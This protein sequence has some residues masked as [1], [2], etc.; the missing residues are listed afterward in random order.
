MTVAQSIQPGLPVSPTSIAD[1]EPT[2]PLARAVP[3][4]QEA[5]RAAQ[6]LIMRNRSNQGPH[7]LH[8]PEPLSEQLSS[9]TTWP[10]SP[11]TQSAPPEIGE[12]QGPSPSGPALLESNGDGLLGGQGLLMDNP[13]NAA[14]FQDHLDPD[15]VFIPDAYGPSS[16]FL[17]SSTQ[18][19]NVP[20]TDPI[21][22][23]ASSQHGT[24]PSSMTPSLVDG[25]KYLRLFRNLDRP[26]LRSLARNYNVD[27]L[28]DL[29]SQWL[30]STIKI[31]D[32]AEEFSGITLE[33]DDGDNDGT[34]ASLEHDFK[35][36]K[37]EQFVKACHQSIV[38]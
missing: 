12:L 24:R 36:V 27:A 23:R 8:P 13:Q 14:S 33:M 31:E 22:Q 38:Y 16:G 20:S 1:T 7:P 4:Q 9:F 19:A 11:Q 34:K 6:N 2:R 15:W 10:P 21:S 18:D 3:S 30:A 17:D 26:Y 28:L 29:I 37:H 32:D 25:D 5:Q 35:D